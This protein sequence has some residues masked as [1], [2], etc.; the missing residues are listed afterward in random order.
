MMRMFTTAATLLTIATTA[1]AQVEPVPVD[2]WHFGNVA[3]ARLLDE[4]ALVRDRLSPVRFAEKHRPMITPADAGT[5]ED[6]GDGTVRWRLRLE[7][8]N[9]L[10]VNLGML[11]DV[12]PSTVITLRNADGEPFFRPLTAADNMPHGEFWTPLVVGPVMEL[13]AVVAADE[14]DAFE[15]G[16]WV[17]D[18]NLGYRSLREAGAEAMAN[19]ERGANRGIAP[20]DAC[21]ID[22]V[23][24]IA[25]PWRTQVNGVGLYTID[26]FLTC[27]GAMLN[28]TAEDGTP[29][30]Y[31]ADH[32][33]PQDNPAGVVTYWNMQSSIC[34][35][36]G[37][38]ENGEIGDGEYDSPIVGGTVL[39][40]NAPDADS[41]LVRHLGTVP[42]EYGIEFLGWDRSF[43]P[44]SSVV[45]ISHPG[46]QE[47]RIAFDYDPATVTVYDG[48]PFGLSAT[49][50]AW[51]AVWEDGGVNRGSSGSPM[52]DQN[53]RVVGTA[54]AA[55]PL[56]I[57]NYC[58]Q[59]V[60]VYGRLDRAWADDPAF[61]AALD[62]LAT[63]QL[64]LDVLGPP[65]GC[66]G[67]INGDGS[68]NLGDFT[69]LAA[70][71]GATGLPNGAG[72]SLALGD[73]D[74]DGDVD[75]GDFTLLAANFGC[76]P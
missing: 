31:S 51:V 34:R 32:C 69:I 5:L 50:F 21:L 37:S 1:Q 71:F 40:A 55:G 28:N 24:P 12:P 17:T 3:V 63:G 8:F 11:Y 27:S 64:T 20:Q 47:K 62:P 70:N 46:V 30:F 38:V 43:D 15:A 53:G 48:S 16:L 52:F 65:S 59:Q 41:T 36:V 7:S 66:A 14:W 22:V 74:D 57:E 54:T 25:D 29:Y 60:T 26:G 18:V 35:P 13:D 10:S 75:L 9:A 2:A 61:A 4:D 68:T 42:P 72:E 44:I 23:C 33:G 67:D 45:G 76:A 58:P 6:L 56:D 73:I 39:V 49:I 19:R